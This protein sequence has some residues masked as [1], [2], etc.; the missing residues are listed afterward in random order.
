[1]IRN[2]TIAT[3]ALALAVD[4][5]AQTTPRLGVAERAPS[6]VKHAGTYHVSTGTW[7]RA[8][9]TVASFGLSDNIYS[10]TSYGGY[11]YPAVGPT[12]FVPLGQL[13]DE[14]V[15]PGTTHPPGFAF[16]GLIGDVNLVV[17]IQIA[18]CDLDPQAAVSGW[19]LD[20]YESYSPCTFPPPAPSGTV[21]V[22]GFPS[23]GCWIVDLDLT[24]ATGTDEAFSFQADGGAANPGYDGD[25]ALDSFGVSWRYTGT[26]VAAAGPLICGDPGDTDTGWTSGPPNAGSNTYYG[27]SGGCP[28]TG[29][30]Y[31]NLDQYRLNDTFNMCPLACNACY[32]FGLYDNGPAACGTSSNPMGGFW[33]EL[34][35]G[36]DE[37]FDISSPECVGAPTT[38]GLPAVCFMYG[39]PVAANNDALLV[40]ES[41]PPNEFGIFATGRAGVPA[42]TLISGNGWVCINTG[43]MGGLGRFQMGNQIKN[44]GPNGRFTLDTGASEWSLTSIPTSTGSYAA[45]TG[46]TSHFQAWFREPVG[47]G[48]NFTGS[49]S[50]TWF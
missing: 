31:G 28:G 11:Y 39:D 1:M 26:G 7:T 43:A 21:T 42:M 23:N 14:G 19:T 10:N 35:S 40:A 6:A 16:G 46:I 18:Y 29:S 38:T 25:P 3:M 50:V 12:G 8:A 32:F 27:E 20:F 33:L 36:L 48:F 9:D 13:I 2:V 45:M 37:D 15:I 34:S 22:A 17:E 30:G 5:F 4:S 47:A 41:V 44:S 49:C 24:A